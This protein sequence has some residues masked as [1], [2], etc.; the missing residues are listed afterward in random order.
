MRR[1]VLLV[2]VAAVLVIVLSGTAFA[3]PPSGDDKASCFGMLARSDL[4][5]GPGS[6]IS[7]IASVQGSTGGASELV[8]PLQEARPGCPQEIR[9]QVEKLFST[10]P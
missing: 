6:G 10:E 9:P 5:G 4:P 2:V 7:E 3:D 8:P 1:L